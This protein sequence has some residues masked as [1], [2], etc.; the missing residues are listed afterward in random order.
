MRVFN[1]SVAVR[2]GKLISSFRVSNLERDDRTAKIYLLP[3]QDRM[4]NELVIGELND[5]LTLAR[6]ILVEGSTTNP[7][8]LGGLEDTRLV[9]S[10][11]GR[12]E[13]IACIPGDYRITPRGRVGF[14]SKF[15]TRM[16]RLEFDAD[17]QI[18][19]LTFF[20]SPFKRRIEKNWAPFYHEDRLLVVY[21]WNPLIILELLPT[22]ETRF[23]KWFQMSEQL[24]EL[25]GS[26]QG[27]ATTNGH[28]FVVHRKY[29][30]SGK[31]RFAHQLIELGHD[32]QPL[33]LSEPFGFVS[34]KV[35]EYCAGV[36]FYQD[37]CLLS[38]GQSDALA[39]IA[40]MKASIV[41]PMMTEKI[42]PIAADTKAMANPDEAAARAAA[43]EFPEIAAPGFPQRVKSK[44]REFAVGIAERFLPI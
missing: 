35:V 18:E 2:N 34:D 27:V 15:K 33:R 31:V 6:E 30:V 12:L 37:R 26:S 21:Q 4:R 5:D 10:P 23:V 38:F 24:K 32:L 9:V 29:I 1:P 39:F 36:A 13:G 20:W 40:D 42:A 22:G 28:L 16:I 14:D 3:G 11:S 19:K 8:R 41:E 17:F 44:L 43:R 25:R 7:A